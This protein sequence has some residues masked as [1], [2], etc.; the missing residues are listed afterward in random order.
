MYFVGK[1][2][3]TTRFILAILLSIFLIS[4]IVSKLK[5]PA[6]ALGI[7]PFVPLRWRSRWRTCWRKMADLL[8]NAG[9]RWQTPARQ[10]PLA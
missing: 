5:T 3:P 9:E 8:A 2:L 4:Q 7:G 6:L 1:R 10:K